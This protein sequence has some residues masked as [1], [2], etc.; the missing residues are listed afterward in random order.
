MQMAEALCDAAIKEATEGGDDHNNVRELEMAEMTKEVL[1]ILNQ[2][3][4]WS[5]GNKEQLVSQGPGREFEA[6]I[7]SDY[8]KR[9]N[10]AEKYFQAAVDCLTPGTSHNSGHLEISA[11]GRLEALNQQR[12]QKWSVAEKHLKAAVDALH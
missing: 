3:P 4:S 12:M 6:S 9:W 5:E 11:T 8:M 2:F 7:W 10:K 1:D